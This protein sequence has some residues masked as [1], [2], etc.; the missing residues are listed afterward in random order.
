MKTIA[1]VAKDLGYELLP[2]QAEVAQQI[3]SGQFG[4][5]MDGR[6]AGRQT[7]RRIV[8]RWNE[9]EDTDGRI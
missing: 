6:R 2:W 4:I 8:K 1:E 3:E 9:Q 7:F 5:Y